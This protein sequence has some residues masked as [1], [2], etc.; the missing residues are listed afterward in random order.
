MATI[1]AAQTMPVI[2]TSQAVLNTTATSEPTITA[3]L[4]T[5]PIV[6]VTVSHSSAPALVNVESPPSAQAATSQPLEVINESGIAI[7]MEITIDTSGQQF[8]SLPD[9]R[10]KI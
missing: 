8:M 5:S 6:T 2:P 9:L 4:L 1:S 10:K 7:G 3:C